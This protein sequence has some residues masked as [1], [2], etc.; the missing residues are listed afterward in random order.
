M[1]DKLLQKGI[2]LY[3]VV[4]RWHTF[5]PR[6]VKVEVTK[7]CNLHCA[8]CRRNFP[9]SIANAPGPKHLVVGRLERVIKD[10]PIKVVRFTGDGE[11]FC[12][13]HLDELLMALRR[14]GIKLGFHD[15]PPPTHL[16]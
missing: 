1:N 15:P 8:G 14:K 7:I 2:N 3:K 16:W 9:E 11:P 12:N 5:M 13:P 6:Q 10:L 4:N